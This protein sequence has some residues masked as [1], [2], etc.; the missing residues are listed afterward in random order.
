[1]SDEFN[2]KRAVLDEDIPTNA[3]DIGFDPERAALGEVDIKKEGPGLIGAYG[4]LKQPI[5][6]G[7]EALVRSMNQGALLGQA[8]KVEALMGRTLTGVDAPLDIRKQVLASRTRELQ[9]KYPKLSMA[10]EMV[11]GM[12]PAA[13]ATTAAG[14]LGLLAHPLGRKLV[15]P[16]LAAV[17]GV[18]R[19]PVEDTMNIG[20]QLL[21][22]AKGGAL[23]G[24]TAL[25]GQEG[26]GKIKGV[27]KK[28]VDRLPEK[29]KIYAN[30]QDK[31]LKTMGLPNV[32]E[33]ANFISESKLIKKR[34]DQ[35]MLIETLLRETD[36][37]KKQSVLE[38]IG[39]WYKLF[40]KTGAEIGD[41]YKKLDGEQGFV[42]DADDLINKVQSGL[43]EGKRRIP[44]ETMK[45]IT[46]E[47]QV[48]RKYAG[49]TFAV[50]PKGE[51]GFTARALIAQDVQEFIKEFGD[52]INWE[53]TD[54]RKIQRALMTTRGE[55]QNQF[56]D[57][58][59]KRKGNAYLD[60]ITKL[61]QKYHALAPVEKI[62]K[63]IVKNSNKIPDDLLTKVIKSIGSSP[64]KFVFEAKNPQVAGTFYALKGLAAKLTKEDRSIR[65]IGKL[66]N[67]YLKAVDWERTQNGAFLKE[68]FT[69]LSD[70]IMS[71]PTV[72]ARMSVS[73]LNSL[74]NTMMNENP[75]FRAQMLAKD[76]AEE[77]SKKESMDPKNMPYNSLEAPN[78][79]SPTPTPNETL[80]QP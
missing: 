32:R 63:T 51:S 5:M 1:M 79:L 54:P 77:Y 16:G 8:P 31:F 9:A 35:E 6:E 68:I 42:V 55:I 41:F 73:L 18:L 72:Q 11:G 46:K 56:Y 14:P 39:T 58:I 19:T 24:A 20:E 70:D 64:Y 29:E 40:K 4:K 45:K 53:A 21:R 62:V 60:E 28:V 57:L 34:K 49:K 44:P 12:A 15:Q 74:H 37:A 71:Q 27:W 13:A 76:R 30:L 52:G 65:K 61:N 26:P 50:S 22:K 69:D 75:D 80:Q 2:P 38:V 25:L 7:G 36:M 67:D 3:E 48:L 59:S 43:V 47:L 23:W 78:N 17:E 33:A 66:Y 10:G